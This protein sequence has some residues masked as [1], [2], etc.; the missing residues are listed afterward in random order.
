MNPVG[1][2]KLK[3][4]PLVEPEMISWFQA[5]AFKYNLYRYAP[6]DAKFQIADKLPARLRGLARRMVSGNIA[7]FDLSGV[8]GLCTLIQVVP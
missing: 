3:S 7:G 6:V 4:I 1:T 5:F 2:Y 8:V